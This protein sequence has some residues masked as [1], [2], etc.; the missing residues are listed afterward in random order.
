[1]DSVTRTCTM[2]INK[3]NHRRLEIANNVNF[4]KLFYQT[5]CESY[6]KYTDLLVL[7]IEKSYSKYCYIFLIYFITILFN[8]SLSLYQALL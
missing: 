1:M 4:T 8:K 2:F 7:H 6:E 5:K 3:V